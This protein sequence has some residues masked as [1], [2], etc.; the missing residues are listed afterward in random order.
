VGAEIGQRR[1]PFQHAHGGGEQPGR[2]VGHGHDVLDAVED[3]VHVDVD[4]AALEYA[5]G[6]VAGI[7]ACEKQL[8]N[9]Q[10]LIKMSIIVAEIKKMS[11]TYVTDAAD[12]VQKW[13]DTH[14]EGLVVGEHLSTG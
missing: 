9:R 7:K 11:P 3:A 6:I 1:P 12:Y 13:L 5:E 10:L 8:T 4:E 14:S 2:V